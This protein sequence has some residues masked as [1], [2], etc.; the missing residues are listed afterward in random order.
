M[1]MLYETH[2]QTFVLRI[3]AKMSTVHTVAGDAQVVGGHMSII[4]FDRFLLIYSKDFCLY[5][6]KKIP[7]GEVPTDI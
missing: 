3:Q 1:A 5:F 6:L 4:L 2:A 7:G